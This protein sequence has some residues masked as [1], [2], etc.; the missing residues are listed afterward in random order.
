MKSGKTK[1]MYMM[2]EEYVGQPQWL[3]R[4]LLINE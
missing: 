3:Y 4:S 2:Q 1:K